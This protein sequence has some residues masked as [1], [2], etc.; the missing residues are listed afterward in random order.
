MMVRH[1]KEMRIV[2]QATVLVATVSV[3]LLSLKHFG[4][5]TDRMAGS[6]TNPKSAFPL[7]SKGPGLPD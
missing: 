3:R 5:D 6:T 2:V 7:L 1:V 4:T